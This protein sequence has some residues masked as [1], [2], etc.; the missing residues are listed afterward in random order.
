MNRLIIFTML[1]ALTGCASQILKSYVGKDVRE[2]VLDYGPATNALDLGQNKRAFQWVM[3]RS[4]TI[5]LTATTAGQVTNYG[6]TSWLNS[7]TTLTGGQ[8]IN[9]ECLY[10]LIASWNETMESWIVTEFRKPK[11]S[12]EQ[13]RLQYQ[14]L[15][16]PKL[17]GFP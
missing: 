5:P 4:V 16:A 2:A 9:S 6:N 11:L 3:D 7:N 17:I 10:T 1:I 8:T 12:C 13:K 14:F 15:I